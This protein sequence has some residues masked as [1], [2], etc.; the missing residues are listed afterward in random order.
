M[1]QHRELDGVCHAIPLGGQ[2]FER[3]MA[4]D[5]LD[6]PGLVVPHPLDQSWS[7]RNCWDLSGG[8]AQL[9]GDALG[10]DVLEQ[11]VNRDQDT[12][13][14]HEFFDSYRKPRAARR[15]G[16]RPRFRRVRDTMAPAE[17]LN[18]SAP[19]NE[20]HRP[21]RAGFAASAAGAQKNRRYVTTNSI[22]RTA[23]GITQ[24]NSSAPEVWA[25]LADRKAH[26]AVQLGPFVDREEREDDGE[27]GPMT[28]P[29]IASSHALPAMT[30]RRTAARSSAPAE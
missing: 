14:L 6:L 9:E 4:P 11:S 8:G 19:A 16:H 1:A 3:A 28:A 7:L 13:H 26:Q 15:R 20:S 22:V 10:R 27:A 29:A 24:A 2:R 30:N 18:P 25:R 12:G 23:Y 17:H 5:D 21:C